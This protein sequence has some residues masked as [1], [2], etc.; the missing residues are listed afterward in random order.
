MA[1]LTS[2]QKKL[3]TILEE[4]AVEKA[5]P[6][7]PKTTEEIKKEKETEMFQMVEDFKK[8]K[9]EN[10]LG[11]RDMTFSMF[12]ELKIKEKHLLKNK[13]VQLDLK[14]P[15]KKIIDKPLLGRSRDI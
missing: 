9:Q 1:K 12:R 15:D 8:L 13:L 14:Y 3:E 2:D 10:P 4:K 6:F 7:I 5:K 11:M